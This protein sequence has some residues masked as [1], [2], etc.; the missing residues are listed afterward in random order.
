MEICIRISAYWERK[1][2]AE[3]HALTAAEPK[4]LTSTD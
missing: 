2:Q 1:K 3:E 4:H